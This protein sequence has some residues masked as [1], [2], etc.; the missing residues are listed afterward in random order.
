MGE[1]NFSS[2][3]RSGNHFAKDLIKKS[4]P[5]IELNWDGNHRSS[6]LNNKRN[7]FTVIR[8]P[9]DC[10]ASWIVYNKDNRVDRADK[11]TEWYVA[12]YEQCKK[13]N[14]TTILFLDLIFKPFVVVQ[15][16]CN[17]FDILNIKF[18]LPNIDELNK[19]STE[20]TKKETV[21]KIK[22]EVLNSKFYPKALDIFNEFNSVKVLLG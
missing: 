17:F 15:F 16:L 11:V 5:E 12:F 10:I 1:I 18:N 22:L 2:F 4:L 9:E 20:T 7:C 3:P 19:N 21:E 6:F 14:I 13:N 8:K